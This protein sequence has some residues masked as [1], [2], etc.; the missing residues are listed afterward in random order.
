M[1]V[2]IIQPI[3]PDNP[4]LWDA[5]F[6]P[7]IF[8]RDPK[9]KEWVMVATFYSCESWFQL[10]RPELPYTEFRF[11]NNAWIQQ[12]SISPQWIG[13]AANMLTAIRSSG[14]PDHTL[15]SKFK[16]MDKPTIAEEYTG[17]VGKWKT[18]C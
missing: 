9:T 3:H 16:I 8:D 11:K 17:I 13:R 2:K 6:V 1:T 15:Q 12:K 10:G 5:P 18:S 4:P 7:I 14:E